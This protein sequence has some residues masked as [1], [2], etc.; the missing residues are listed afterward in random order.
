MGGSK[1]NKK[2]NN[3]KN[4]PKNWKK[5]KKNKNKKWSCARR[6]GFQVSGKAT[7]THA[8]LNKVEP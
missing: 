1:K 4:N 8:Q 3:N 6:R 2:K 7:T 5:N